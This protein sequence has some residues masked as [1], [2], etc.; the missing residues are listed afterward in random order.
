MSHPSNGAW[1]HNQKL[2]RQVLNQMRTFVP[3]VMN[4]FFRVLP[5]RLLLLSS[6]PSRALTR[7]T[8]HASGKS[9]GLESN[10]YAL[11][12]VQIYLRQVLIFQPPSPLSK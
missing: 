2:R 6:S 12:A 8:L 9:V 4:L 7:C 10:N 3:F 1:P 5:L 11:R